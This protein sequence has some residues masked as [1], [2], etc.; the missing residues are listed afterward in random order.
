MAKC[1][2]SLGTIVLN[3]HLEKWWDI[4]YYR[5]YLAGYAVYIKVDRRSAPD[6]MD[7]FALDPERPLIIIVRELKTNK[8]FKIMQNIARSSVFKKQYI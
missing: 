2:G 3:P 1:E 5:F 7:E 6:V 8:D 4:T